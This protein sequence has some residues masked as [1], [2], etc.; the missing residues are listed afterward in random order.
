MQ[1]SSVINFIYVFQ[2]PIPPLIRKMLPH[3]MQW[4]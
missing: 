4:V 2:D 3:T 1:E